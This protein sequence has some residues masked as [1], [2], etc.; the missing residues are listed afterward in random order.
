MN[1]FYVLVLFVVGIIAT[2]LFGALSGINPHDDEQDV[3]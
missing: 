2:L 1:G 3:E